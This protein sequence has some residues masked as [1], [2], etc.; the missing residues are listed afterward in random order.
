[1]EADAGSDEPIG[2][3]GE[4]NE[5]LLDAVGGAGPQLR[6][7]ATT[8]LIKALDVPGE[9]ITLIEAMVA[10]D[11]AAAMIDPAAAAEAAVELHG[12]LL[13]RL[14]QLGR[15]HGE[16]AVVRSMRG[17]VTG[18]VE[19]WATRAVDDAD[20][21]RRAERFLAWAERP[22]QLEAAQRRGLFAGMDPDELRRLAATRAEEPVTPETA[23]AV[24][25]E[26]HGW[27]ARVEGRLG[28]R[29]IAAWERAGG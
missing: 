25:S 9:E 27:L 26:V 29:V 2:A 20:N 7:V 17:Y 10:S 15:E 19:R 21:R 5:R 13:A 6:A 14:G 3:P 4:L 1:M 18:Q 23:V 12:R 24:W 16:A 22:E 11:D 28:D 8:L